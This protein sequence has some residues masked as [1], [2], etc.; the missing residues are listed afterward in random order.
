MRSFRWL[1]LELDLVLKERTDSGDS[2]IGA[3]AWTV[4]GRKT[5]LAA[6][7]VMGMAALYEVLEQIKRVQLKTYR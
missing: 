4:V 7:A 5:K 2:S 1:A 6:R 3:S